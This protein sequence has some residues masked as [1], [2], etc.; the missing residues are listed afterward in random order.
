MGGETAAGRMKRHG[1]KMGKEEKRERERGKKNKGRKKERG[2][3]DGGRREEGRVTKR[4]YTKE[5]GEQIKK[6]KEEIKTDRQWISNRYVKV[7]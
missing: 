2:R 4:M 7:E 1:E 6:R 3:R 5:E